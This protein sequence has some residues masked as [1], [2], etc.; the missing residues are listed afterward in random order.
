M[1]SDSDIFFETDVHKKSVT[2]LILFGVLLGSF[3]FWFLL[4]G[5]I[6][7]ALIERR[8]SLLIYFIMFYYDILNDRRHKTGNGIKICFLNK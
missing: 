8:H 6:R 4:L 1:S 5:R 3:S 7:V 2:V